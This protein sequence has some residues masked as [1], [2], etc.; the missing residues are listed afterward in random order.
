M[1]TT[2]AEEE[3]AMGAG[4]CVPAHHRAIHDGS[5]FTFGEGLCSLEAMKT[6]SKIKVLISKIAVIS[7]LY[8]NLKMY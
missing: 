2:I 8:F 7:A 6:Y 5:D 4:D 1:A 3:V